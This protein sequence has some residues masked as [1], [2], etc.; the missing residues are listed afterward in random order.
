M[1]GQMK[2]GEKFFYIQR[3]TTLVESFP[4]PVKE[5]QRYINFNRPPFCSAATQKEKGIKRLI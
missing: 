3:R 2:N 4:Y 1:V 5:G